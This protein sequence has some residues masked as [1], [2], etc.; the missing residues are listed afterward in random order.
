MCLEIDT[1]YYEKFVDANNTSLN[2]TTLSLNED[3]VI[4]NLAVFRRD[5]QIFFHKVNILKTR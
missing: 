4:N 1:Q 5:N 3:A 2:K